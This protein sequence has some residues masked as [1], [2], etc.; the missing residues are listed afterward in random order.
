MEEKLLPLGSVVLLKG[1]KKKLMVFGRLQ[2]S[3]EDQQL[4]DYIACLF[5]EGNLGPEYCFLFNHVDIAEVIYPGYTDEEDRHL[6]DHL[7]K[8][9]SREVAQ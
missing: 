2:I 7:S 8:S 6:I 5:P 4:W 3:N 1:G 9:V